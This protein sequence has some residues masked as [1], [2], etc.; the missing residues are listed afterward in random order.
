[1]TLLSRYD[2]L[3]VG[4]AAQVYVLHPEEITTITFRHGS[5]A[6][7]DIVKPEAI[8]SFCERVNGFTYDHMIRTK[9]IVAPGAYYYVWVKDKTGAVVR[10]MTL[11]VNGIDGCEKTALDGTEIFSLSWLQSLKTV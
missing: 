5:S 6:P 10:H 3:V 2:C 4:N 8:E 1:M 11:S 7:Y 9:N